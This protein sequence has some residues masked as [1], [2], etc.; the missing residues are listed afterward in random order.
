MRLVVAASPAAVDADRAVVLRFVG[1][2]PPGEPVP[3][4]LR[5]AVLR[6]SA[7]IR[8]QFPGWLWSWIGGSG[9]LDLATWPGPVSWWWYT[10]LSE[11]SPLRSRLIQDLYW[12]AV[13]DEVLDAGAF[14]HVHWCGD[15]PDLADAARHI[16]DRHGV[17][18]TVSLSRRSAGR[19]RLSRRLAG[20]CLR[21]GRDV[22]LWVVFRVG[23]FRGQAVVADADVLLFSRF[24]VLWYDGAEPWRERMYGT[25]PDFLQQRGFA[26]AYVASYSGTPRAL[27]TALTETRRR[28]AA[29]RIMFA[30]ACVPLTS[31]LWAHLDVAWWRRYWHLR[32]TA[33]VPPFDGIDIRPLVL[34][35]LDAEVL[36]I[37]LVSDRVLATGVRALLRALPKAKCICLPFEYQPL[38]RAVWAG[39]SDRQLPVVGLQT[40]LF[41]ANQMGFIFPREQVRERRDDPRTSPLPDLIAAY[42]D[43][44]YD[45]FVQRLGPDRVCLSGGVRYPATRGSEEHGRRILAALGV[46]EA[47]PVML[48]TVP[49]NREEAVVTMRSA[50]AV[51]ATDPRT[52]V[53]LKFH[54]HQLL[55]RE[56]AA[57]AARLD[58]APRLRIVHEPL[59]S[60]LP[61][62]TALVSGGSSTPVEAVA[63][64]RMPLVYLPVG[65]LSA[66]PALE[67][68]DAVFFWSTEEE[69]RAG[70]RSVL[71]RDAAYLKRQET[72]PQAVAAHFHRLDGLANE[73][74]FAAVQHLLGRDRER[75]QKA[76]V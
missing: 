35:E 40:G 21:L 76:E 49:S 18:F 55:H 44:A 56:A 50:L 8:A 42:G 6:A 65:S 14:E 67:V 59:S 46:P 37:E 29:L 7:R 69:L 73:R 12:L 64:G 33:V 28:C 61:I 34:R 53:L 74:L 20:R 63:E 39:V 68:P 31:L 52:W 70:W 41:T 32:R 54:Y 22:A 38:E 25:W 45:A 11:M 43:V 60:L 3:A 2:G 72:W 30:E 66:N 27:L 15:D 51:A 71:A 19:L 62:A 10:A 1:I 26:P 36:D 75:T 24:P 17:L 58:V 5:S 47:A 9:V 23:G 48:V 4:G 16:A 13:L 57:E